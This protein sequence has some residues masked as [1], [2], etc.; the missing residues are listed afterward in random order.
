MQSGKFRVAL[1][2]RTNVGKST[3]FNRLSGSRQAIAFDRPGVT[4]DIKESLVDIWGKTV[5][6]VDTPGM[7]DYTEKDQDPGL[8]LA[9]QNKLNEIIKSSDLIVF[10]LDGIVGVTPNDAEI[11]RILRKTGKDVIILVNKSENKST[12]STYFEAM[13][14]GY[15]EVVKIS[16]EHGVGIDEFLESLNQY[17][18]DTNES[19]EPVEQNAQEP[20]KLAIVGRPNV[21]KSTMVNQI[22]GEDKQL[23]ADFAGVTR[24]SSS[25]DFEFDGRH[26]RIIDTPG[27]RRNARVNDVLEKISVSNSRNA[28]RR[29]DAVVLVIDASTLIAGEIEKQ[30]LTLAA[31]IIKQGKALVIAFNKY[32][33]TPYNKE[34]KPEFLKRNFARSFSQLKSVPF[35]FTSATG[36]ENVSKM[37]KTVI[38]TYDKQAK[39]IKTADLND[40]LAYVNQS[41]LLRSGSARFKLKYITQVGSVPPTFLIFVNNKANMRADHERFIVN[42]LKSRFCLDEVAINVIFREQSKKRK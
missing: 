38:S 42:S 10:V 25:A 9:I 34:D 16:A 14:F 18:P 39:K 21:G 37:L 28:Y 7:F 26:I 19:S 3:L 5:I 41:D 20:I 31:D 4:R 2:G 1:I 15:G 13:N 22:L 35:L 23:V 17:L 36:N 6:L 27:I 24:E 30:D 11:I 33:K 8:M 29:A 32:D 12:E 40:W